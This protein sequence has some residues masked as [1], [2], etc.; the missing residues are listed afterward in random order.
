MDELE[1]RRSEID[2]AEQHQRRELAAWLA[3]TTE[4]AKA[5]LVAPG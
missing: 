4:Q 5:E 2:E 3:L 1:R